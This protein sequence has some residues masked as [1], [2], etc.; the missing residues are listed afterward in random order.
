MRAETIPNYSIGTQIPPEIHS[1]S[2][3]EV[4]KALAAHEATCPGPYRLNEAC[5]SPHNEAW[6]RWASKKQEL[7][8]D[9]RV[10]YVV[11]ER[12]KVTLTIPRAAVADHQPGLGD[13]R[14]DRKGAEYYADRLRRRVAEMAG[15]VPDSPEWQIAR[16]SAWNY[17]RRCIARAMAD[18]VPI[19][20]LPEVPV[21]PLDLR[22]T[23]GRTAQHQ[24]HRHVAERERK[25]AAYERRNR[26]VIA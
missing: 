24:D 10:A 7:L 20:D 12:P 5:D 16:S 25:R 1:K 19:P 18:G 3:P 2:L 8:T 13:P 22:A 14:S 17:R 15:M 23:T 4:R 9:E 26:G 11:E 21:L 6:R